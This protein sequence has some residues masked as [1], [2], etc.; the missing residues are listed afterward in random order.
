MPL[1][2]YFSNKEDIL[3]AIS[4]Q[5]H[6][7]LIMAFDQAVPRAT[8][9]GLRAL[10]RAYVEF[11][12]SHPAEYQLT[13]TVSADTLA[14]IEKDFSRPFEM[15]DPGARSFLRFKDHLAT[16]MQSKQLGELDPM[17]ATQ[18]LWFVGHGVVSLLISRAHFPWADRETL[19][20][21]LE[22]IVISGMR[23]VL[24]PTQASKAKKSRVTGTVV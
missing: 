14:P 21:G 12:L 7:A 13:F 1:Y 18:I 4:D 6:E 8:T 23:A 19:M 11:G 9:E 3:R 24:T 17:I 20:T 10:I 5:T 22:Q 16:L 15:Q 2:V